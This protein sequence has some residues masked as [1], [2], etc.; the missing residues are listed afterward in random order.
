M[1][2]CMMRGW[3]VVVMSVHVSM[4]RGRWSYSQA[5]VH[6]AGHAWMM[7]AENSI[8]CVGGCYLR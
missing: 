4:V 6:A 1:C 8:K 2:A 7:T 5:R 3:E